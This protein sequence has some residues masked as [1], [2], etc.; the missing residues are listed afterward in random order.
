MADPM[1]LNVTGLKVGTRMVVDPQ[2]RAAGKQYTVSYRVGAHGPFEDPVTQTTYTP[3]N[4]QAG[5]AMHVAALREI[6]ASAAQ[7]Q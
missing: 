3:A 6:T 7:G 5:L 2:T 1:Q 4:V